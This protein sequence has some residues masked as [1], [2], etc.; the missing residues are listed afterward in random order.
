MATARFRIHPDLAAFLP[1]ERRR[2]VFDYV[3]ARA[4]TLKNA[5][6]ALGIPHTEI[7]RLTVNG[8]PATL[9]RI[10]REGDEIGAEGWTSTGRVQPAAHARFVADAHLGAL[11]RFLRMLGFDTVHDNGLSDETI[12]ELAL[13]DGRVVLT[14]D[15]ELLKCREIALGAYVRALAPALQ[16][17]E[18]AGRFGLAPH[19][20]PFTRCLR[21]NASLLPVHKADVIERVPEQVARQQ[22]VFRRCPACERIY[23]PG[24]H[25]ARMRAAL[26]GM[27]G[28]ALDL[29]PAVVFSDNDER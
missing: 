7:A 24:S 5:L 1:R 28:D 25:L 14:R 15:R 27:L 22:N 12:R 10:V 20:R 9:D 26:S 3:C 11:A 21:C 8:A 23:W 6:E 17:R 4:A 19:A 16:L 18:I 29:S 2:D 13:E